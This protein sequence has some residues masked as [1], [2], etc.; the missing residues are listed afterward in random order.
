MLFIYLFLTFIVDFIY[1]FTYLIWNGLG[2]GFIYMQRIVY[3]LSVT[4]LG[5][6]VLWD[7]MGGWGGV[8]N[9]LQNY[10]TD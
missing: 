5:E 8:L 10:E 6:G 3:F 7:G 9:N 4:F 2:T 1:L